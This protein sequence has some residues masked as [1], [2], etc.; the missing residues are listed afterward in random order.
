M[1][2]NRLKIVL[3]ATL[4]NLA[5]EYSMRGFHDLVTAPILLPVLF[6][7]YFGRFAILEDLI[8]RFKLT[9]WQLILSGGLL[10]IFPMAF[11]AGALFNNPQFL[12][13]NWGALFYLGI[14]WWGILQGLFT[15]YFANR[16]ARRDWERPSMGRIAWTLSVFSLLGSV[17]VI[18][19][20]NPY[21]PLVKPLPLIMFFVIIAGVA[22][23]LR[24]DIMKNTQRKPWDFQPDKVIDFL[25]FGSLVLF[26]TLFTA[27]SF[28]KELAIDPLTSS[29]INPLAPKI[30]NAWTF[31]YTTIYLI[32]R[33]Q[34]N[35]E[36]SI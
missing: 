4:F 34:S 28:S 19:I 15:S 33:R 7:Y 8:L 21:F 32:H 3:A 36:I 30:V 6:A 35:T 11:A 18:N 16:I 2:S 12:G 10:G 17:A 13:I 1:I 20:F 9:N 29:R 25:S 22:L 31:I 5:F 27:T 14:L 26:L 23:V 24:R